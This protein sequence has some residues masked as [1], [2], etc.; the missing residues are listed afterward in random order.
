MAA[1]LKRRRDLGWIPTVVVLAVVLIAGSRLMYLSVQHH[2]SAA[3]ADA[4]KVLA[5]YVDKINP[6]LQKL[7]ML[8]AK[9]AAAASKAVADTNT[10]TSLDSLPLATNTFWM[11]NEDRVLSSLPK[12]SNAAA[13]VASEWDTAE[14]ARP[15]PGASV[16]GPLRLGSQWLVSARVPVIPAIPGVESVAWLGGF[17]RRSR[18]NDLGSASR[19]THRCR[20]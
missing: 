15:V 10:F 18:R 14:S 5:A 3:R 19:A 17:L 16:L 4:T 1:L 12:E 2:A 11:T 13:G 8:A 7:G 6:E 20:L 9:Q